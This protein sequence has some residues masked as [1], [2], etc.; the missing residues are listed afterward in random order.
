MH[1]LLLSDKW[2]LPRRSVGKAL[3]NN[4]TEVEML[5][6]V[7]NFPYLESDRAIEVSIP[8]KV[9]LFSLDL[10]IFVFSNSAK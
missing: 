10:C 5:E 9:T 4:E 2:E 3:F 6:F 8:I 7:G 1:T